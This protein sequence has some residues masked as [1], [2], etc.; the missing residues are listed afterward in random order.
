VHDAHIS[1]A[2]GN[3]ITGTGSV[4][5]DA[6]NQAAVFDAGITV[7]TT[8]MGNLQF[9]GEAY[10]TTDHG[11]TKI[12]PE[13]VVVSSVTCATCDSDWIDW[14]WCD[15]CEAGP[16]GF[17]PAA[18]LI[19]LP[20]DIPL[21]LQGC[22]VEIEAAANELGITPGA[23][24]LTIGN[25]LALN[26]T[27]QACNAC[28]TLIDAASILRDEDGSRMAA[29][30]QMFNDMAP[31]SLPYSPEMQALIVTAFA[32]AAEGSQYATVREYTDAFVRY[33][34]V[35]DTD[36]ASPVGDSLAFVMDKYGA[37]VLGSGNNNIAAF[38]AAS[39]ESGKTYGN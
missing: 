6:D 21:L 29:M 18:A 26:P 31:S 35:L 14:L 20:L 16:S 38:L 9:T 22:P 36:L 23:M 13:V 30:T 27:L 24:Q 10:S 15:D 19:Q 1:I 5:A 34:S 2:A 4:I 3:L 32:G 12:D 39:L 8:D 17:A 37:G 11:A 7:Y 28:A 33:F 25:A